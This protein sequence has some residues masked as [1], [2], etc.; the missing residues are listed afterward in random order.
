M[1]RWAISPNLDPRCR[2][3]PQAK[4][5]RTISYNTAA[6]TSLDHSADEVLSEEELKGWVSAAW[7][8]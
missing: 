5:A 8:A 2:Q 6:D 7:S 1:N 3:Y 4:R